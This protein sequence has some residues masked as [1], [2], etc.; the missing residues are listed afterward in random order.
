MSS[1]EVFACPL[2]PVFLS[3]SYLNYIYIKTCVCVSYD[4]PFQYYLNIF[5]LP[6]PEEVILR[7][8]EKCNW[9]TVCE[10]LEQSDVMQEWMIS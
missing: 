7:Q 10:L 6:P 9:E 4:M 1:R 8:Q 2:F 5:E 3:R